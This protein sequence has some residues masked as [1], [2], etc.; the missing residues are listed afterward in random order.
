MSVTTNYR[1][2]SVLL[3]R[4]PTHKVRW[5][6]DHSILV[7]HFISTTTTSV[8][9]KLRRV[10]T[11]CEVVSPIKLD[12]PLIICSAEILWQTKTI[13]YPL[14]QC[15]WSP[16]VEGGD[17]LWERPPIKSDD[18]LSTWSCEIT[19]QFKTIVSSLPQCLWHQTW[20]GSGLFGRD[21]TF[22]ARWPFDHVILIDHNKL[23]PWNFHY[24]SAYGHQIRESSNLPGGVLT[25]VVTGPFDHI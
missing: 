11:N 1:Q 13:I 21:P 3:W 10:V 9:T 25:H 4:C 15:L 20:Q 19:W 18:P 5:F 24:H 14:P 22:Q 2:V 8:A 12:D 17:L 23:K 7:D 6:F 16:N